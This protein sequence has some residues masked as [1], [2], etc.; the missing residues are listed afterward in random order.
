MYRLDLY[1]RRGRAYVSFLVLVHD[2]PGAVAPP[3]ATDGGGERAARAEAVVLGD[4]T[5]PSVDRVVR[6]GATWVLAR[7]PTVRVRAVHCSTD[8]CI[9]CTVDSATG[10]V[11]PPT[12]R[13]FVRLMALDLI[14]PLR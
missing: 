11:R 6:L 10:R 14:V 4:L 9:V 7:R 5:V 8:A 1:W 2:A 13:E 12:D 3:W